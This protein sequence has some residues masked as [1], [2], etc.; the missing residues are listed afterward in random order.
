M[1]HSPSIRAAVALAVTV[2][3]ALLASA[4]PL[5][6]PVP[7]F[8]VDPFWPKPL[9]HNWIMGLAGGLFVGDRDPP[10]VLE[11]DPAGNV[12]QGWGGPDTGKRLQKFRYMGA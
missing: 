2:L 9:P 4:E 8:Q 11:F 1:R 10:P 7:R 12:V 6:Q 5:A 3:F